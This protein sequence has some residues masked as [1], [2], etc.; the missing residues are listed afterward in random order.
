MEV[1]TRE[2]GALREK[3][4]REKKPVDAGPLERELAEVETQLKRL[5]MAMGDRGGPPREALER[6]E[7]LAREIREHRAAGRLDVAEKLEREMMELRARLGGPREGDRPAPGERERVAGRERLE[8]MIREAQKLREAGRNEEA[9]RLQREIEEAHR[10]LAGMREGERPGLP[11]DLRVRIG[12]L[13]AAM[14]NLRAAGMPDQAEQVAQQIERLARE[15]PPEVRERAMAG[16]PPRQGPPEVQ[17]GIVG[18]LRGEIE[19]LHRE[20]E[21]MRRMIMEL[22]EGQERLL[23]ELGPRE[24]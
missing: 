5:E 1:L 24:R 3:A 18:E 14:E 4:I 22:R 15:L 16:G 12:H 11:P 20:S 17:G 23:R 2:I 9:E 7:A 19:R 8:A 6:L 21:E 10:R 13:R